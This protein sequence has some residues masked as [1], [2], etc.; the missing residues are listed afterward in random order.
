MKILITG[1]KLVP[2]AMALLQ[3]H[4][5]AVIPSTPYCPTRELQEAADRE[6][7]DA[8]IV[9]MGEV[10]QDV[11]S[12][13][14]KLRVIT[15]HGVGVNTIDVAAATARGIPV[16]ITPAANALAVAEHALALILSLL[17]D[18][19]NLDRGIRQGQWLKASTKG[20][21]LT[22]KHVGIVGFG[23]IGRSLVRLLGSFQVNVSIFDPYVS[24]TAKTDFPDVRQVDRFE[25]LLAEVDILTLHCP[26]VP[27]T[28]NLIGRD[29][30]KLM[31][32]GAYL[33]NTARGGIV[34]EAALAEALQNHTIAGAG[35]DTFA[36]EPPLK[37]NPLWLLP[38]VIL[39]PHIGGQTKESFYRMGIRAA[40]NVIGVLTQ[41]T[42][43]TECLVNPEVLG[44]AKK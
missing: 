21:E 23:N 3:E 7:V 18:V 25:T 4:N 31:K 34:D 38:N 17:R 41:N 16:M 6:Q 15:K 37:D 9:R 14:R 26:L 13:S 10:T 5:I 19:P 1:P 42:I 2:E 24:V 36:S 44:T 43:D 32:P 8:I 35:L 29:E 40:Q 28:Q 12:A 20:S 30:L 27:E 22:G 39:S 11:I 33:I